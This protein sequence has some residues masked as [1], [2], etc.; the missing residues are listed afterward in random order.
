M[1][2]CVF[3]LG[4]AGSLLAADLASAGCSVAAY[5]PAEVPTP[6]GVDRFVHP[7]LAV[8][9]A[10]LVM[11][12]TGGAEAEL[13][14][15]Q[16]LDAIDRHALYADLSTSSPGMKQTL[17]SY[18]DHRELDF[19][20]VALLAMVPGA[21]LATP[22]IASGPGAA[23]Y[24]EAL[25]TVGV[26]VATVDGPAGAAA[27]KKL[28]RS[29]MMKGTAAVIIEAVRAGAAADDL[30]WLWRNLVGEIDGADEAWMRRLVNG[31]KIHARRRTDEMEAAV[32]MLEELDTPSSMTQATV[33]SLRGLI[34]GSVPALPMPRPR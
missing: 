28:L 3:G 6:E 34:H 31:S 33:E 10:E 2:V 16:A 8:R 4:E 15:L 7:A 9:R 25:S 11:A 13:A 19:A 1:N 32:A 12:V 17:A 29:V 22:S 27:T 23:R 18:A 20:D 26:E 21:G 24:A 30:A 14:L 5:D